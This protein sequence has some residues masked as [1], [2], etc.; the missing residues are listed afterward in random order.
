LNNELILRIYYLVRS[1]ADLGFSESND[2]TKE[3]GA[4]DG[5]LLERTA[6]EGGENAGTNRILFNGGADVGEAGTA[7][8]DD[9]RATK[10]RITLW[11]R[12]MPPCSCSSKVSQQATCC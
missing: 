3:E 1:H 11:Q 4:N 9:R 8:T 2:N 5:E 6:T 12:P 10:T 7:V